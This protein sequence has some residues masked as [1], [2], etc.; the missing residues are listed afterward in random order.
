MQGLRTNK[1]L[2]TVVVAALALAIP[3]AQRFEGL[4]T[5]VNRDP[6]GI[7]EVCYGE[8]NA[9]LHDYTKAQCINLLQLHE[10]NAYAPQV[11]ACSPALAQR[12]YQLAAAIDFAYNAGARQYCNSAMQRAFAKGNWRA[13]C[14][15]FTRYNKAHKNGKIITLRGLTLRRAAERDICIKDLT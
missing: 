11:I 2:P 4:N 9:P 10:A 13:G 8:T 15:A 1:L 5:H 7:R 12:K 14:D 6:V 3:L